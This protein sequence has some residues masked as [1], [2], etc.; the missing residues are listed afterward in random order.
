MDYV[1]YELSY[2]NFLLYS[3]SIPSYKPT[4]EKKTK[5]TSGGMTFG[6]FTSALKKIAQ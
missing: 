3:K 2:V 6:G 1:L 5:T 4:G